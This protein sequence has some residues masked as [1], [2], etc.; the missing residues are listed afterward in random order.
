MLRLDAVKA[1]GDD[2]TLDDADVFGA[3]FSPAE[4]PVFAPY[5]K[6]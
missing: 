4:V 2:Q 6:R 1:A 5:R 3:K